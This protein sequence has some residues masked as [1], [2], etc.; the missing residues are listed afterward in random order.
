VLLA[1]TLPTRW[2][3]AGKFWGYR[4]PR[5]SWAEV[6][7]RAPGGLDGGRGRHDAARSGANYDGSARIA[8][9][10]G[11]WCGARE[12]EELILILSTAKSR[13]GF[14]SSDGNDLFFLRFGFEVGEEGVRKDVCERLHQGGVHVAFGSLPWVR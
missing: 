6:R 3:G 2:M 14:G 8:G 4:G 11:V 5:A 12:G 10:S 13:R 9:L 1:E 7:V